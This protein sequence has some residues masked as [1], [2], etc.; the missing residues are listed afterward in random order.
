[1]KP[2]CDPNKQFDKMIY[3]GDNYIS[4]DIETIQIKR[5]NTIAVYENGS[6]YNG[7]GN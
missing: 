1:M 7:R 5:A 3:A 2:G 6:F 4:L